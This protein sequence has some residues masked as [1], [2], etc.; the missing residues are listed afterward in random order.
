LKNKSVS[1]LIYREQK[2]L[3]LLLGLTP[4]L[5]KACDIC[6]SSDIKNFKPNIN[7]EENARE[8]F[9]ITQKKKKD[10]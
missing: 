6:S 1:D 2:K 7:H 4:D 8:N 5:V 3:F 9:K 10:I